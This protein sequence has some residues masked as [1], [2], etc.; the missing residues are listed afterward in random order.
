MLRHD[1]GAIGTLCFI[2]PFLNRFL[3]GV[4]MSIK[5]IACATAFLP[6]AAMAAPAAYPEALPADV[7]SA[8]GAAQTLGTTLAANIGPVLMTIGVAFLGVAAVWWA[9]NCLGGFLRKRRGV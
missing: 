4:K 8:L 5:K 1:C 2:A 7:T 6:V 9:I 3:V